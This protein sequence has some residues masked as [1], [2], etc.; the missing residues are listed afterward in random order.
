MR[1]RVTV[2]GIEVKTQSI[3]QCIIISSCPITTLLVVVVVHA[4][5]ITAP[6]SPRSRSRSEA[7]PYLP[8]VLCTCT[9]R[10]YVHCHWYSGRDNSVHSSQSCGVLLVRGYD[11]SGPRYIYGGYGTNKKSILY[12]LVYVI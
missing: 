8:G 2:T 5:M 6:G 3:E 11:A 7:R 9:V 4:D 1:Q 10:L 12:T